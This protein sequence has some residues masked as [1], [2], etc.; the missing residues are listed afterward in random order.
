MPHD[1]G[2]SGI[3][4]LTGDENHSGVEGTQPYDLGQE[5]EEVDVHH[6]SHEVVEEV[7]RAVGQPCRPPQ[8]PLFDPRH[9]GP[10]PV[11]QTTKVDQRLYEKF[12][13]GRPLP[14]AQGQFAFAH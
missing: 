8:M 11:M 7:A 13:V 10:L 12:V 1:E 2:G 6:V 9:L 3:S 14:Q 4:P 5:E